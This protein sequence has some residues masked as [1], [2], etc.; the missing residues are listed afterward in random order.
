M[1]NLLLAQSSTRSATLSEQLEVVA[2]DASKRLPKPLMEVFQQGIES[3][4]STGIEK[5]AK[6]V[7]DK[8]IDAEL[9][10]WNGDVIR[11]SDLWSSGPI[12][13]MWYRGGWCPYCNVQL[14][15]MQKELKNI[16]GAGAKLVVLTP[17]LPE[18]AK[19]TA[20][21]NDLD[22]IALY[23][24]EN[25]IAKK[26]GLV[27]KLPEPILPI[28]RDRIK[29]N[30]QNGSDEMELPLSAT[31]LINQQG[32]I[33][34]AFLDADYK[35]RAEP[36]EVVQAVSALAGPPKVG[37]I[38]PDFELA[39]PSGK[40]V[41]LSETLASGPTTIVVLRGYPGY[42]C[43]IC[44]RQVGNYISQA[45]SF[46]EKNTKVLLVYPGPA[47]SLTEKATEFTAGMNIPRNF[48]LVLDPDYQFT[49]QYSL[50]WDAPSET[51][52]PAT[53][54]VGQDG[55]IDYV[56]I[57]KGHGGRSKVIEVLTAIE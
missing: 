2:Q 45:K 33:T 10:G 7:G 3:V 27:F 53:F 18:K 13:L 49:N 57:S 51:A 31:Y 20:E 17:E 41:K 16:E 54:V 42:Q 46:A 38:A 40:L 36:S 55:V 39:T 19:A 50:R 11:L 14:Q 34:Y 15:A 43:G 23:D 26:Y 8:A 29:L 35:K 44:T 12:V 52:Y 25:V 28:Y 9:A 47:G 4:R 22:F 5:S 37:S 6:Q 1:P 30:E 32:I 24:K 56:M 21:K 48:E